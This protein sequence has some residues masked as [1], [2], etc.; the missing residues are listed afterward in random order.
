[1]ANPTGDVSTGAFVAEEMD[2]AV[3]RSKRDLQ[4][5]RRPTPSVGP[6][7][8]LIAVEYCGICGTDLHFVMEGW[9]RP[10][11]I[12]GHEYSGRIVRVGA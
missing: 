5:E 8:V 3:Y 7:D 2:A 11:S 10:N 9:G 1:M 12:G 4:I 6:E